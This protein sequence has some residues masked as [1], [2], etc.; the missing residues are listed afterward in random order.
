M[1]PTYVLDSEIY[2]NYFLIGFMDIAT[3]KV[4]SIEA[5]GSNSRLS[6][7]DRIWLRGWMKRKTVGFNSKGFDLPII[8]AAI[9]GRTVGELKKIAN[10]IISGGMK[11]WDVEREWGI[12]IPRNLDHIDLIE[13][14]PGQ[15]SLKI[16]NGRLHGKRMQDL[17]IHHDAVLSESE[18]EEV[19]DYWK[20]DL[21]ATKLLHSGL[22]AHLDL[23]EELSKQYKIDLRSKS[24]A[25]V[26]EAII[27]SEIEKING[28]RLGKS[29]SK[30]VKGFHY[31][32]PDYIRFKDPLM[33]E[34]VD[35]IEDWEFRVGK[36]GK[37]EMPPF[38]AETPIKMGNTVYKM[39]IGGLHSTEER[40]AHL[41]DAEHDLTD[42]DVESFYPRIITSLGLFPERLGKV[43][44]RVYKGIIARRLE[45][46]HRQKEIEKEIKALKE[47]IAM[48]NRPSELMQERLAELQAE[49][50][51]QK[52]QNEGGKIQINGSFGKLGSMFSVL[53]AP[54]LLL[55]VTLTGQLSLLMLIHRLE[56]EGISVVSGNTDGIVVR[57]PRHL[58]DRKSEIIAKWE[59][60]T[61]F[62]TEAAQYRALYAASVNNY[63][64]VKLDGGVKRKGHYAKSGLD[65]KKNPT[66]EIC[67]DAVADFLEKGIPVSKT[68]RECR[69]IRKFVTVRNV[70]GG[71]IYGVKEVEF[72]R[73]SEKTGKR[74][75]P[76]TKFDASEAVYL[77]KAVRFYRSTESIGALHYKDSLNKVPKSEGCKPLMELP[78]SFPDDVDFSSYIRAARE[79]LFDIGYYE[80]L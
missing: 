80:E 74:L 45:A 18:I 73:I 27:K 39:G 65:E 76:G 61:G 4:W 13:V 5:V 57:C 23:R 6:K 49:H 22:S 47:Q 66:E 10:D 29:E 51:K 77:G 24:D 8:Y 11:P 40:V 38:L 2:R 58:L 72:E 63:F 46:K 36:G 52:V 28:Q 43:F 15:A 33:N 71:A 53:F 31:Q 7:E 50:R 34:I 35:K 17:P 67:S 20:N 75:K 56:R 25:Q 59:S 9:E 64:A 68:I 55:T 19:Y 32:A 79:M 26:A 1:K 62:K 42:H 44:L 16:Y 37:V 21:Q 41:S 12:E 48:A 69:D 78:D 14:S 70:T 54:K 3:D 30:G 60:D